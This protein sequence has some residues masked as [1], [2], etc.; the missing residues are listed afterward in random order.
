M[1]VVEPTLVIIDALLYSEY[2]FT[3]PLPS[4]YNQGAFKLLEVSESSSLFKSI[5]F[6]KSLLV[7]NVPPVLCR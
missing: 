1:L 2:K 6:N 7:I 4:L 5:I 3:T